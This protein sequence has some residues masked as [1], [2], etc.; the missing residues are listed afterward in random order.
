MKISTKPSIYKKYLG[1]YRCL[2]KISVSLVV[3]V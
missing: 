1:I 2:I 3:K